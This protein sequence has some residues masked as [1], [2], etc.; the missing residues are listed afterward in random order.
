MFSSM[1][2]LRF[3]SLTQNISNTRAARRAGV[4]RQRR[5]WRRISH[6]DA[7]YGLMRMLLRA[8][9]TMRSLHVMLVE[10]DR[11]EAEITLVTPTG[12]GSE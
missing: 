2:R 9:L 8:K 3:G 4:R 5:G 6:Y 11:V 1:R 10:A 7:R 12:R